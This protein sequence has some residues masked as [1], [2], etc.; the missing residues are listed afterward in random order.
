MSPTAARR[1]RAY[2]GP[3]LRYRSRF[4]TLHPN[5]VVRAAGFQS[6]SKAPAVHLSGAR[7]LPR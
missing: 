1:L 3:T 6:A 2:R 5:A 7:A 4:H